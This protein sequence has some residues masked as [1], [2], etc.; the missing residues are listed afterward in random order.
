MLAATCCSARRVWHT[1]S[2]SGLGGV[3]G[4]HVHCSSWCSMGR[5][6]TFLAGTAVARDSSSLMAFP[7]VF[8]QGNP[9]TAAPCGYGQPELPY[10]VRALCFC[11][12]EAS[13]WASGSFPCRACSSGS[14]DVLWD[15]AV[16]QLCC[17]CVGSPYQAL[18]DSCV[19][20]VTA[21][22]HRKTGMLSAQFTCCRE[23][24]AKLCPG[25]QPCFPKQ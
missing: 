11:C 16:S 24:V 7:L 9:T 1:V 10:V 20:F 4:L 5:V 8:T 21:C 23:P 2:G 19:L 15:K 17:S 25:Q 14:T 18:V 22:V 12:S 3:K 6:L 13:L